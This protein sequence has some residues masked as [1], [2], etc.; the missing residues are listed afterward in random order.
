MWLTLLPQTWG[1]QREV[2]GCGRWAPLAP[3][4]LSLD[5][6]LAS[7]SP[8][9]LSQT[10][11]CH[12]APSSLVVPISRGPNIPAAVGQGEHYLPEQL[13]PPLKA[14]PASST[15]PWSDPK[16]KR[17][18]CG[19]GHFPLQDHSKSRSVA[20]YWVFNICHVLLHMLSHLIHKTTL[21]F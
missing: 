1:K 19:P 13:E 16:R 14:A 2:V 7:G 11:H 5:H 12:C 18:Q 10:H 17:N 4:Y 21:L 20:I 3:E 15:I 6:R 9:S 8:E